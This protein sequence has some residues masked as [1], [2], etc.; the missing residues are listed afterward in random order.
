MRKSTR[1]FK[2]TKKETINNTTKKERG[3]SIHQKW[4]Q[5]RRTTIMRKRMFL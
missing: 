5:G 4:H 3:G 2:A 1:K